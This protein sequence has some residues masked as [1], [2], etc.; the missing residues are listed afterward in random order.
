MNKAYKLRIEQ[1]KERLDQAF[2]SDARRFGHH[3][4]ANLIE[5]VRQRHNATMN[6]DYAAQLCRD[7]A[8]WKG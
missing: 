8:G 7:L 5:T 2:R 1:S 6:A 3:G 4:P